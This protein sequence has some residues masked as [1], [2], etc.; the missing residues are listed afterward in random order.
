MNRL[1][2]PR[3]LLVHFVHKIQETVVFCVCR[4]VEMLGDRVHVDG[5]GGDVGPAEN[6][7]WTQFIVYVKI[8]KQTST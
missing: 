1:V 4:H 8:N 5:S 6:W 7:I 2:G 3:K